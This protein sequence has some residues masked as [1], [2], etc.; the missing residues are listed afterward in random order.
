GAAPLDATL[1]AS[2]LCVV[3]L[4]VLGGIHTRDAAL[5]RPS[6]VEY[7]GVAHATGLAFGTLATGDALLTL[8]G[9]QLLLIVALPSG[10]GLLML[11][12]WSWRRWLTVQRAR[13]R[14]SSRTLVVGH[15][16][17]VEYVVTNLTRSKAS[18]LGIVGVTLLDE[19]AVE[20]TVGD[21]VY[22]VLGNV[23]SVAAVA[24]ERGA[25]TIVV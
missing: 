13:G 7:R 16:E 17:D 5:F 12:G 24:R 21:V 6:V 2:L 10:L 3:W 15:R 8:D 19:N 20:L 14:F 11:S 1:R 25:D 18:G 22:P 23:N 4:S 9:M